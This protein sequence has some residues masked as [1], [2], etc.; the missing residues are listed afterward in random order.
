VMGEQADREVWVAGAMGPTTRSAS[1][2]RDVNDPGARSVTF[3][4]LVAAYHEQ[5][6][7]L[8]DGG[9]DVLLVETMFD[10]LNG[11]AALF[12]L[13]GLFEERQERW[14]VMASV[15]ITDRA[16]RNLS[17]QTPEAFWVSVSHAP[18][19]SVG[20]N[21]A[22]GARQM[23][24]Y[25]EEL[26]AIAPVFLSSYPNAGLPNAFGGFDETPESLARDLEGFADAGS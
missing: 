25:V 24:P 5:A 18:L 9:V 2:S 1:M 8:I 7:G 23:R 22:L 15:T 3:R 19:L 20:I 16:G 13:D 6:R 14:P 12:A 4:E 17:G 21:C 26:S 11:K 10:T